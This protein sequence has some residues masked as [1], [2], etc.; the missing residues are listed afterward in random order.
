MFTLCTTHSL[1]HIIIIS[2]LIT[3]SCITVCKWHMVALADHTIRFTTSS[4]TI[5]ANGHIMTYQRL[6]YKGQHTLLKHILLCSIFIV[7]ELEGK[8]MTMLFLFLFVFFLLLML[9]HFSGRCYCITCPID[10][11]IITAVIIATTFMASHI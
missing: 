9:K 8:M 7:N 4:R 5:T 3:S 1:P 11:I 6:I 10:S 2:L